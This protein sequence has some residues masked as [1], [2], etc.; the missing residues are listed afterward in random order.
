M[1]PVPPM[2]YVSGAFISELEK[3]LHDRG[4]DDNE[5]EISRPLRGLEHTPG[6]SMDNLDSSATGI[7]C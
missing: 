3:D 6:S 5:D 4:D 7:H 1:A 2:G